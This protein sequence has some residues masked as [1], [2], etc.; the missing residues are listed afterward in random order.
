MKF[1][2][3]TL[4]FL[5]SLFTWTGLQAQSQLFIDTSY[6]AEQMIMDFFDNDDVTVSNVTFQGDPLQI[7]YFEAANT[8]I[9]VNTGILLSTGSVIG[10]DTAAQ[11]FYSTSFSGD[12]H[13]L[14][15]SLA[16]GLSFDA[17]VIEFDIELNADGMFNF[18]YVFGSEE[19]P[20]YV[21]SS[22]NDVFGFF[23]EGITPVSNTQ[24][25]ALV[26][27]DTIPVAIN[28]VND[29]LNSQYYLNYEA[30]NGQH[31]VFDGLTVP[32][33][34]NFEGSTGNVFHVV[35]GVTDI[36]DQIFDSGVFIGTESLG[37]DSLLTPPSAFSLSLNGNEVSVVNESRYATSW[38]WDF[39]DGTTSNERHPEPHVYAEPGAYTLTLITQNWCCSDTFT[40]EVP[41]TVGATEADRFAGIQ[42]HPNPF[43]NEF[44]IEGIDPAQLPGAVSVKLYNAQ[45]QMV[46]HNLLGHG[47]QHQIIVPELPAGMYWLQ[48]LHDGERVRTEK[49]V[50]SN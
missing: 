33:Q 4:S 40:L 44:W 42:I 8:D 47:T 27:G 29:Q 49:L 14:L 20:E 31:V 45:G 35:V 19:Y 39:G 25:I 6:T 7:A 30:M 24:Q 21:F 23:V 10:I 3:Y 17:A 22:F 46:Q 11:Y 2:L 12:G 1:K 26:P 13:P 43:T 48:V 28:N 15:E 16:G 41:F 18:E 50:K 5:L 38:H 34:A 9:G 37:G 36:G 32:L